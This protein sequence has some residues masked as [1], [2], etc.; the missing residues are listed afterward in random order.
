MKKIFSCLLLSLLL[1]SL[2]LPVY[3]AFENPPIVDEAGYL[4]Q[5]ELAE[6]NEELDK[7]RE[8][9]DFE[10]AIYTESDMTSSTAEASA[11]DIYDYQGY[12]AG[13][14]DDGIMLYI[15]SSTREYHFTTHGKG[16]TYF[17]SNGLKYLESIVVPYLSESD[18]Y[19]AFEEYIETTDELLQMAKDGKPYN[20]KQY[21]TKYLVGVILVCLIA[22]LLIAWLMMRKKLKKMKTAVANDYAANYIKPGS[23]NIAVS[24]DLFL[25]SNITKTEKPKSSSGTHTSSSGRTHGGRGGSF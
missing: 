12:G 18:Y 17:N 22:P 6:L 11:D 21:S 23:M 10:V 2:F 14:N 5:S 4:M 16:L 3:A 15:C 20:E 24:R 13:E 25:Y 19:E 7:I 9:Y 1:L 8:K